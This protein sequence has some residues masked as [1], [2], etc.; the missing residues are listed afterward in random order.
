MKRA[1]LII[2]IRSLSRN[3]PAVR[4]LYATSTDELRFTIVVINL[5]NK[6]CK[7]NTQMQA[8]F[9][10]TIRKNRI[11][12]PIGTDA[13]VA[14]IP[15][16]FRNGCI[17]DFMW[18]DNTTF[19]DSANLQFMQ[20]LANKKPLYCANATMAFFN[21]SLQETIAPE[22]TKLQKKSIFF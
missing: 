19:L 5:M 18:G 2:G 9:S 15:E 13:F 17:W 10:P 8:R 1:D 21:H 22:E 6:V 3:C 16:T 12:F 4:I 7:G 20:T 14:T 11:I